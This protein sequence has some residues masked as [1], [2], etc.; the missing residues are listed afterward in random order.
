MI[1]QP[2]PPANEQAAPEPAPEAFELTPSVSKRADRGI[3]EPLSAERFR[4]QFTAS[5]EL[6]DKL[7]LAADLMAHRNP[8]RDFAPIVDKALDLLITELKK[9]LFGQ[10]TRPQRPRKANPERVTNVTK[11]KVFDRDGL[12][13]AYVDKHGKR[14]SA[15]AFLERNHRVPRGKGGGP[16]SENIRHLCRSH[17]Q[18]AA[19]LAYDRAQ[20]K[21]AIAKRR[22]QDQSRRSDGGKQGANTARD[23]GGSCVLEGGPTGPDTS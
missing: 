14:C 6:K 16:D 12:Q 20:I 8:S 4:V 15:R 9:E 3:V 19:E 5:Q 2:S 13:C 11:R 1:S 7:E 22:A 17:N 10:T 23:E 21:R 18:Y